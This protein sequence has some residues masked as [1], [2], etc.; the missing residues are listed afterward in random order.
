[1]NDIFLLR[2]QYN[3]YTINQISNK[4]IQYSLSNEQ[5]ATKTITF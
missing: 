1:M 2:Y 4:T 5:Q 3:M